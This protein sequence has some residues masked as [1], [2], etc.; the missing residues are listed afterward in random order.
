MFEN[1]F[2]LAEDMVEISDMEEKDKKRLNEIIDNMSK[3]DDVKID[4]IEDVRREVD[5][6]FEEIDFDEMDD[7]ENLLE[8]LDNLPIDDLVDEDIDMSKEGISDFFNPPSKFK[9]DSEPEEVNVDIDEDNLEQEP[10]QGDTWVEFETGYETFVDVPED[11]RVAEID[12]KLEDDAVLVS[13]PIGR[14]I[15]INQ[16]PDDVDSLEAELKGGKLLL[17]LN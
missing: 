11:V 17:R 15:D 9:Y 16:I 12:V 6:E 14:S 3:L 13:E 10:Y 1:L 5:F 2:E 7:V 8:E 4:S